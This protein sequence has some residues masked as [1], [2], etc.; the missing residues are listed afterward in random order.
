MRSNYKMLGE[1]IRLIDER[2]SDGTLGEDDLYG[3]SVT[4]E[5]IASHANLV[6]VTFNSY[7][8]VSPR[9]F[10]YIP[11]TSRRGDKI[12]ISLNTMGEKI[13]V[14]SIC[15]V[16]EIIDE[17]KLL[18]EYLNL[19]FMRPEFDRYARFM[20]NGSA[21]EVFDWECMC[22]VELPVP[23][24][25][26][27][28]KIVNAYKTITNRIDLLHDLNNTL[29]V[30]ENV[31]FQELCLSDSDDW[32][33]GSFSDLVTSNISG[34]W[35]KEEENGNNNSKVVC[36]RGTDIP[37]L[38]CGITVDAPIRYILEKNFQVK[39]LPINALVIEISGGSP[40]Q[41]TGRIA[42]LPEQLWNKLE[43]RVICS[44]FCKAITVKE[45]YLFFFYL[46]WRNFYNSNRLFDYENS[47]IGLKN[48]DYQ[49]FVT[50]ETIKL[51]PTDVALKLNNMIEPV[52]RA[53]I[54][55][56]QEIEKLL[57]LKATVLPHIMQ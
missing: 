24:I 5:F 54:S 45:E 15:T 37:G 7:K 10:A 36:I 26:E 3:I 11:D 6:G 42:M 16:F 23:S 19:W 55:N 2:N 8:V 53:I 57:F 48:F 51:P 33:D 1:Y 39:T 20:S 40:T 28:N 18:P 44:N 27:Q 31:V 25:S 34:D 32:E 9:Q 29:E 21:R 13:I 41:S 46:A 35:G 30:Q 50:Q 14:S 56:G 4:K 49:S 17:T 12:A 47:T 52:H 38:N 43:G 22:N